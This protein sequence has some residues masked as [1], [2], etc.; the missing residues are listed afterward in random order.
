MF[1]TNSHYVLPYR[2]STYRGG[3]ANN[4]TTLTKGV[5]RYLDLKG[6]KKVAIKK[7]LKTKTKKKSLFTQLRNDGPMSNSYF[8]W[9]ARISHF[10]LNKSLTKTLSPQYYV[11]NNYLRLEA[12]V[13]KQAFPTFGGVVSGGVPVIWSSADISSIFTQ[14][15]TIAGSTITNPLTQKVYLKSC[16]FEMM[17]TNQT[18][19]VV[20]L[21]I[22]EL[23]ARRDITNGNFW[24]PGEAWIQGQIDNANDPDINTIVGSNPFQVPAFTQMY[25]VEKVLDINLHSGGHHVHRSKSTINHVLNYEALYAI[26]TSTSALKGI[27]RYSFPI[28]HGYPLNDS[29]TK[30]TISTAPVGV[31]MVWR[32]QYQ[33]Y[34]LEH[35]T[36]VVSK[37]NNLPTTFAVGGQ[38]T[39]DLTGAINTIVSTS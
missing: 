1:K 6:A 28:I 21:S 15:K 30:T 19:D 35:S 25:R 33:Y 11:S 26:G 39:N 38:I 16:T 17:F 24:Y 29:T 23:V 31:D 22:Y 36:N 37:T 20:H 7:L 13:G 4:M 9:P 2:R 3:R 12:P 14:A 8:R 18:N 32:K 10:K 34:V 5:R 27:T